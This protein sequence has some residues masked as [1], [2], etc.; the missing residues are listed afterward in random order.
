MMVSKKP[1]VVFHVVM[2]AVVDASDC[3][4]TMTTMVDVEAMETT[5][6]DGHSVLAFPSFPFRWLPILH[7]FLSAHPEHLRGVPAPPLLL[8][9]HRQKKE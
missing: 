5:Y 1:R 2:A 8:F 6:S 9:D 4:M 3:R 7:Q